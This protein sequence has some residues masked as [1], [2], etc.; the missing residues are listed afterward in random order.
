LEATRLAAH[1]PTPW[2]GIAER[3]NIGAYLLWVMAL[4]LSQLADGVVRGRYSL[5]AAMTSSAPVP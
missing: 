5:Q 3:I 1:Q 2:L 4:A